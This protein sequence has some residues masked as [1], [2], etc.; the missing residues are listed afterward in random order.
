MRNGAAVCIPLRKLPE[1]Q[2]PQR[3]H[4][5]KGWWRAQKLPINL[6]EREPEGET[7]KLV[8][9]E[10]IF[11]HISPTRDSEGPVLREGASALR[12]PSWRESMIPPKNDTLTCVL[13]V[14][15]TLLLGFARCS[16]NTT[17]AP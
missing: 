16:S 7:A 10:T 11:R 2:P 9:I 13:V 12:R 1:W 14:V 5:S 4:W 15:A 8:S 17:K 6:R 3:G